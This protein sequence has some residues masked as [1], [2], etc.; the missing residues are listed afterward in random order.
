M[1][2]LVYTAPGAVEMREVAEPQL[3][4]DEVLIAVAASGICGSDVHGYLGRSKIRIPPMVMG[5]EAVGTVQAVGE[6][7]R[8]ISVGQ[9]VVIQPVVGCGHCRYCLNGRPNICPQRQLI[10]GHLPGAFAPLLKVPARV[11]YPIP[12]SLSDLAAPLVEP[13][14][15]SVHMLDLGGHRLYDDVVV[16][17][18]GTLG[19][20]T[21]A[22]ARIAGARRV[23]ATDTDEHRRTIASELGASL[24][25]DARAADTTERVVS[26]TDGG[27]PLVIDCAGFTASRQAAIAMARPGGVVVLLGTG[28]PASELP[29]QDA[30]NREITLRGSYSSTDE[31]FRRAVAIMASGEIETSSWV[32][33]A[34]LSEGPG[35]FKRLA[36]APGDL[37]KVVFEL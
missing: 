19:L 20:L 2:A 4:A 23:I 10:G 21:V 11:V 32:T 29:V 7:V 37:V 22:A 30:I 33:T 35:Y 25:L 28:E 15:N 12:D 18:C 1:E 31:E 5:H 17:G 34:S 14:G 24:T 6:A 8:D 27:S 9:R 3:H 16:L 36:E 13:L 26:E